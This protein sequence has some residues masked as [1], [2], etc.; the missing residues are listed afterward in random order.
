MTCKKRQSAMTHQEFDSLWRNKIKASSLAEVHRKLQ[1]PYP[2]V[3]D[4]NRGVNPIPGV[5][6]AALELWMETLETGRQLAAIKA[7]VE[8][9]GDQDPATTLAA[10][11]QALTTPAPAARKEQSLWE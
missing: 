5:A 4:W 7:I 2:T 1:T 11:Q 10:I 9:A 3:R 6:K 8:S